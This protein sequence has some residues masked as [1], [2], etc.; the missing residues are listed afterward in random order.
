MSNGFYGKVSR[1]RLCV[2]SQG[3]RPDSIGT[4]RYHIAAIAA[5]SA[6]VVA[7]CSDA[8]QT[9]TTEALIP[10][11]STAVPQSTTSAAPDTT[12]RAGLND[13]QQAAVDQLLAAYAS[14]DP[15][16]VLALWSPAGEHY[17]P[18]IEFDLAM[19]GRWSDVAC[20]SSSNDG[21]RCELL[22][23]NDLLEALD[24]PPLAAFVR[25][26]ISESGVITDWVYDT[27]NRATTAA[28]LQPF[29]DWVHE[30]DPDAAEVMFD[31]NG[32]GWRTPD[33]YEVWLLK[34][35]EFL[36]TLG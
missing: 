32:F 7:A 19:G 1:L 12:A 33:A 20:D 23:T 18:D 29:S 8:G 14:G 27:G 31:W 17:R 15:A 9:S 30:N 3:R 6:L 21:P 10:I 34:V 22:Y 11:A 25:L 36:S 35:P 5:A 2:V 28:Y 16:A 4:M 24:A 26:Q 13:A